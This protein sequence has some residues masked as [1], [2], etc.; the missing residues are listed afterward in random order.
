MRERH[1]GRIVN[2][3]SIGGKVSVPHLLPYSASKFALVGLSEGL[4]AQLANDNVYVTT[5][6]PGLVRIAGQRRARLSEQQSAE[7]ALF[8]AS[9]DAPVLSGSARRTARRIVEACRY[10]EAEVVIGAPARAAAWLH[11]LLPGM[12]S[13]ALSILNRLLP[14]SRPPANHEA[15]PNL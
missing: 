8:A 11:G 1:F 3:A 15:A 12:T 5:V 6:C 9:D 2:I 4:R 10:A 7:Y 14:K 13:E